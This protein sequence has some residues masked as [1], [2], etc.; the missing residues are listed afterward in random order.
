MARFAPSP[1]GGMRCA[2]SPSS[3]T[4]GT[5]PHWWAIGS[6]LIGRRVG[7]VSASVISAVSCVAQPSNSAATRAVAAAASVKSMLSNHCSGRV[8]TT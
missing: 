7:V 1:D 5:R 3:V 2:A 4:P 6:E 8:S